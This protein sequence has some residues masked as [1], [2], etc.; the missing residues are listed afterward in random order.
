MTSGLAW[1][2]DLMVWLGR[3]FPRLI[4]IKKTHVGVKFGRAGAVTSLPPGLYWYWPITSTVELIATTIRTDE[5]SAQ[6]IGRE[7]VSTATAYR[8]RCPKSAMLVFN[9]VFSQMDDRT[10]ALL[11]K[12]Y[13]SDKSNG[14]IAALVLED[15]RAEFEPHG[16]DILSVSVVQRG[17]A[18]P[19]KNIGDW[20]RHSQPRLE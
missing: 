10:Q 13:A 7:V 1:L 19:L 3:W 17:R 20:A 9:D 5:I 6:L 4:L 12:N 15:M 16:V 18:F 11:T 2:N 14:E 8:I